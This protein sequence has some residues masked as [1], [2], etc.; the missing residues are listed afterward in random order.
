[1]LKSSKQVSFVFYLKLAKERTEWHE[2]IEKDR[3][4]QEQNETHEMSNIEQ[5]QANMQNTP[6]T[7]RKVVGISGKS[8]TSYIGTEEAWDDNIR[9]YRDSRRGYFLIC[10]KYAT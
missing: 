6:H 3:K 4:F 2:R 7:K 9:R 5:Q 8:I 1:M 10:V